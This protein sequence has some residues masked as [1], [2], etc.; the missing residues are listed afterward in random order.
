MES[1]V[2]ARNPATGIKRPRGAQSKRRVWEHE[3]LNLLGVLFA[4][5]LPDEIKE[6]ARF[7]AL[8]REVGC[9]PGELSCVL[10]E[11]VNLENRAMRFRRTKVKRED[12]TIPLVPA[13]LA[14]VADQLVFGAATVRD[15]PYLFTSL[16]RSGRMPVPFHYKT[17]INRLREAEVVDPD[18]HAH[19]TRREFTSNAFENGLSHA[20]IM[21]MTGHHSYAAVDIYNESSSLHPEVRKRFTAEAAMRKRDQLRALL[22]Q[23]GA[24]E[25]AI[26]QALQACE[27]GVAANARP[28]SGKVLPL[29][30]AKR[31]GK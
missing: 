20:D 27:R 15:S 22:E 5:E 21:A 8:E 4:K 25:D 6:A 24:P 31:K 3:Q 2:L 18:F 28:E 19:A 26:E 7:V 23:F 10:R 11:D 16:S 30:T 17:A 1:K 12:R 9:R 29:A 13:A 14:F